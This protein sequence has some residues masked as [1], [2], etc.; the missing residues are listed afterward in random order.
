MTLCVDGVL[1][2]IRWTGK[3]LWKDFVKM[4]KRVITYFGKMNPQDSMISTKA[5]ALRQKKEK[6]RKSGIFWVQQDSEY[7]W[8]RVCKKNSFIRKEK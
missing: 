8:Q 5:E 4:R 6:E 3:G 2:Y 1:C 7:I